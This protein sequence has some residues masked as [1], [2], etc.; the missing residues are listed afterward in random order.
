[1]EAKSMRGRAVISRSCFADISL[2]LYTFIE[3]FEAVALITTTFVLREEKFVLGEPRVQDF[4]AIN[5]MNG[6]ETYH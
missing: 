3:F 6:N 5:L 2:A 1:M 4:I